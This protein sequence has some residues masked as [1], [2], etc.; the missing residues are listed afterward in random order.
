MRIF[1]LLL[2]SSIAYSQ[3]SYNVKIIY[4]SKKND[5][6]IMNDGEQYT[7]IKETVS[8]QIED[9]TIAIQYTMDNEIFL[10]NRT[11]WIHKGSET[12]E[13]IEWTNTNNTSFYKYRK[14]QKIIISD[15][16]SSIQN[17]NSRKATNQEGI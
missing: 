1:I 12:K 11:L 8:D 10:L 9:C 4:E 13:L 16:I 17:P 15:Q 6:I 2:L 7:I 14:I 3:S 5:I